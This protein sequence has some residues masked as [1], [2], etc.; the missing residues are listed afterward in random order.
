MAIIENMGRD[1]IPPQ[2]VSP[3]EDDNTFQPKVKYSRFQTEYTLKVMR[4]GSATY[5]HRVPDPPL[6]QKRLSVLIGDRT[7][8]GQ[9]DPGGKR[10]FYPFNHDS[11]RLEFNIQVLLQRTANFNLSQI[12]VLT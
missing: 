6:V 7:D 10:R 4:Q 12:K 1:L 2:T 5:R 9:T 3:V 8:I 11:T